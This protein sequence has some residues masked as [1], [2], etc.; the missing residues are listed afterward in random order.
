[1]VPRHTGPNLNRTEMSCSRTKIKRNLFKSPNR[2]T[3]TMAN[4]YRNKLNPLQ[5]ALPLHKDNGNFEEFKWLW[6]IRFYFATSFEL[7]SSCKWILVY[8][9]YCNM[10]L[11]TKCKTCKIQK[12]DWCSVTLDWHQFHY[13]HSWTPGNERRDQ[14]P[15]MSQCLLV[16]YPNLPWMPRNSQCHTEIIALSTAIIESLHKITEIV[17]ICDIKIFPRLHG[18]LSIQFKFSH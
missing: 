12:R 7:L 16:V 4:W 2:T 13:E 15:G 11:L 14:M 8:T 9:E 10:I 18:S 3:R 5:R 6:S 17:Q 1:M